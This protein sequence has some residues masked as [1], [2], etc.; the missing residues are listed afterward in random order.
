MWGHNKGRVISPPEASQAGEVAERLWAPGEQQSGTGS[1][2]TVAD[3][4]RE[5]RMTLG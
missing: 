4:I 5:I 1:L 3:K 2:K